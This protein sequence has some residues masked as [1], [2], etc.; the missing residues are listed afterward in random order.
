MLI[1]SIPTIPFEVGTVW[2]QEAEHRDRQSLGNSPSAG[3]AGTEAL[4]GHSEVICRSL[5]P[6]LERQQ[7]DEVL[8]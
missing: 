2:R 4:A 8:F 5:L 3:R 6:L 7:V 1:H